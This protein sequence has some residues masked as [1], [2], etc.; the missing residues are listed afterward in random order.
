MFGNPALLPAAEPL[1]DTAAWLLLLAVGFIAL[2]FVLGPFL[3]KYTQKMKQEPTLIPFDPDERPAPPVVQEFL[4]NVEAEL[5]GCGFEVLEHVA[6]PDLVPNVKAIF[7]LF[8]RPESD[9]LAMAVAAFGSSGGPTIM[10]KYYVEFAT[11]FADGF[12]L[13]TNNSTD[14]PAYRPLPHKRALQFDRVRNAADLWR[15]HE[16]ATKEFGTGPKRPMP[17]KAAALDRLRVGMLKEQ[18][19]QVAVGWLWHDEQYEAFRP[20]WKGACLMTWKLAWPVS[21]YRRALRRKNAKRLLQEW[22]LTEV[23]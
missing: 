5:W 23:A 4:T 13:C 6:V 15:I 3:I 11:E 1:V 10:R 2:P 8:G 17:P 9:D 7:T 18:T 12:V 21:A 14:E 22:D 19:D 20:T 16:R